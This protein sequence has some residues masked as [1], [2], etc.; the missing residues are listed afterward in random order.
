MNTGTAAER[1][2]SLDAAVRWRA[3]L[4][5]RGITL[6]VTNGC[7]DLLH[8]GHAEYRAAAR[9]AAGALLVLVNSD[10]SVRRLKGPSRPLNC[11]YDR[12]FVLA[13]LAAVDRCVIFGAERCAAELAALC[14]D[15]YVKGGDYTVEKLDPSE[16]AA[17]GQCGARICFIPFVP[18]KSTTAVI[19]RMK[20]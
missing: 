12:A 10:D 17:L 7:F 14:P 3:G 4:R 18:G 6:A 9:P 2:L 16:R 11:E 20:S 5:E 1:I 8:R 19:E 15:V 13:S